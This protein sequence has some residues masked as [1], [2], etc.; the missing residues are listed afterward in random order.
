ME[1][2]EGQGKALDRGTVEWRAESGRLWNGEKRRKGGIAEAEV[3]RNVRR[4][5]RGTVDRKTT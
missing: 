1:G 5:K 3:K 2:R 4:G